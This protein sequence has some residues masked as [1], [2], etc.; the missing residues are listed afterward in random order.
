MP[1][2]SAHDD[3]CSAEP[4]IQKILSALRPAPPEHRLEVLAEVQRRLAKAAEPARDPS[5]FILHEWGMLSARSYAALKY[6]L[7]ARADLSAERSLRLSHVATLTAAQL[8]S[9]PNFG[10]A[11]FSEVVVV[12]DKYGWRLRDAHLSAPLNKTAEADARDKIDRRMAEQAALL[13]RARALLVEK[14][15][16]CLDWSAL[17]ERY[18]RSATRLRT[19]L[20]AAARQ[21]AFLEGNPLPPEIST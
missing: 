14:S 9:T 18:G 11:C 4:I 17:A 8:M 5:I 20:N 3:L 10:A 2:N 7:R 12:L 19:Q 1:D 15:E 13:E 16:H 6:Q 21:L